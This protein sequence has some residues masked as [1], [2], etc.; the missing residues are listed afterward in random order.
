MPR[1]AGWAARHPAWRWRRRQPGALLPPRALWPL[2][3]RPDWAL[4][5]R[6]RIQALA[7]ASPPQHANARRLALVAA[8]ATAPGPLGARRV[9]HLPVATV[10]PAKATR[11][12]EEPAWA[13]AALPPGAAGVADPPTNRAAAVG[14]PTLPCPHCAVMDDVAPQALPPVATRG[15]AV[16]EGEPVLE[17]ATPAQARR[18]AVF[19]EKPVV[20]APVPVR[21]VRALAPPPA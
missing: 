1:A 18:A 4:P 19:C 20:C 15:A 5:V 12:A 16:G 9:R 2:D 8:W 10:W 11:S 6:V 13:A 17:A 14:T 7:R 3:W 21:G